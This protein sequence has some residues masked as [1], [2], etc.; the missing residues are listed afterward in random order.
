MRLDGGFWRVLEELVAGARIVIDRP[1]GTRHPRYPDMIYPVD[2]GYLE[3]THA[4]DG[5][6][7]DL[8]RGSG[9][10]GVVGIISTVDLDK[11]D[12]EIKILY[13][14][15]PH[16]VEVIHALMNTGGMGGLLSLRPR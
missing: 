13:N 12:A 5:G 2:Y 15:T 16:E 8:W 4:S 1:A 10:G 14:C 11:R 7:I 9:S 6:G 3:G